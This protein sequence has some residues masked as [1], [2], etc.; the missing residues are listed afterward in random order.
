MRPLPVICTMRMKYGAGSSVSGLITVY[1]CLFL[2]CLLPLFLSSC[3]QRDEK[4]TSVDLSDRIHSS[5]AGIPDQGKP[6]KIAIAAVISPKE[7]AVYYDEMMRYVGA[8][9]GRPIELIQ[10]K[11]YDEVNAMIE[12]RELD[13]AFVCSGP[14]VSGHKKFGMEL[15]VAPLLYGKPFYQAYFIVHKDSSIRD[16]EGLKGRR[17]AFTDPASNTGKLVPTYVLSQMKTTPE[18]YFK[19]TIFT[20]SHDNS[21]RAVSKRLV[22]GGSV[23][24]LIWDFY[25][26][27]KPDFVKDTKIIY[28]SP[29]Y[30]IPPVVVHPDTPRALK[31]DLKKIF[32]GMHEDPEGKKILSELRIEKFVV[33]ADSSY[34]SVRE[35][36]TWIDRQP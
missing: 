10:K 6:V 26:D 16:I 12:K 9:L 29:L 30:G 4:R 25:Q 33:P 13:L 18:K 35:M 34:N 14:Y 21:I 27:R 24:G 8:K 32:M 17:F 11:T 22:E 15:L 31:E 5:R 23:D 2:A 3:R 36:Q 28:R 19:E 20:Y 7:T 1:T